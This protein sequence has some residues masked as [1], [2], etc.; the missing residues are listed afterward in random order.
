MGEGGLTAARPLIVV[1]TST[2]REIELRLRLTSSPLG[3]DG[4]NGR[5][6]QDR[7]LQHAAGTEKVRPLRT[8]P[9]PSN[10]VIDREG[11]RRRRQREQ[12]RGRDPTYPVRRAC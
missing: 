1:T 5:I 12:V 2:G 7:A 4:V 8:F 10:S 11:R 6:A 3:R 9:P